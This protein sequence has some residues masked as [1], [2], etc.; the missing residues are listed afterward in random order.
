MSGTETS[1]QVKVL[2]VGENA[3]GPCSLSRHLEDRGCH[4]L[5]ASS[6]KQAIR[7]Y[8]EHAPDLVLCGDGAEG[9]RPLIAF[10]VGSSASV[11]RCHLVETSCW[12]LPVLVQGRVR[13]RA[14]ALRPSEFTQYLDQMI[15]EVQSQGTS[16]E[17]CAGAR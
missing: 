12:W 7:I 15:E 17:A 14:P 13:L 1:R 2:M 4:C 11:F 9:V 5:F 16:M 8:T 3:S 10:L 6:G